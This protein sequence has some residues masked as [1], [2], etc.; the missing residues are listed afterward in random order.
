MGLYRSDVSMLTLHLQLEG[1]SKRNKYYESSGNY[2]ID[3]EARALLKQLIRR[4]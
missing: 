4:V 1:V 3:S 2:A